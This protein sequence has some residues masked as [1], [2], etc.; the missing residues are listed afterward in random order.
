MLKFF[1][2]NGRY[3]GIDEI[4]K[5]IHNKTPFIAHQVFVYV[6]CE[7]KQ[8]RIYPGLCS[9]Y[10]ME[11]GVK[12]MVEKSI[13]FIQGVGGLDIIDDLSLQIVTTLLP[14]RLLSI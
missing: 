12:D 9:M 3:K 11:L 4:L 1:F 6:L 13:C 8:Q 2:V 10:F 7:K 14:S 5:K